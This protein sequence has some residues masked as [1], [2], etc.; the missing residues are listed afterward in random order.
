MS[1]AFTRRLF[2]PSVGGAGEA[3]GRAE[4]LHDVTDFYDAAFDRLKPTKKLQQFTPRSVSV[5]ILGLCRR[6]RVDVPQERI[7]ILRRD[8]FASL[9][10]RPS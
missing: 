6:C 8:R 2:Y 3:G 7:N 4:E 5:N 9:D 10:R 1:H